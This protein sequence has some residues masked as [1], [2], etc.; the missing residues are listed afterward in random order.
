MLKTTP[1]NLGSS[2]RSFL[3]QAVV[4]A[5]ASAL[6]PTL[7]SAQA[8]H[9]E[10]KSLAASTFLDLL[11]LPDRVTAYASLDEP[12]SLERPRSGY[13]WVGRGTDVETALG[14]GAMAIT[15]ASP[16]IE[17]RYIHL[18]WNMKVATDLLVLGDAWERSY[19]ELGWRNLVPER[20][21]P[22]YFA[23]SDGRA[24]HGY[25]VRTGPATL[26]FWQLDAEGVSLWLN[27][28]NGRIG[29]RGW[30]HALCWQPPW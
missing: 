17:L 4:Q 22:W 1:G 25:G 24:T 2:R 5:G 27:T 9:G 29:C 3:K 18:R 30:V 10:S 26:C 19:G 12:L 13:H 8:A 14:K 21:M 16:G 23:T 15:I 7:S 20:V 28:S 11:R 6:L